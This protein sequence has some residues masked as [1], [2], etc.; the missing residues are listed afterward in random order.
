[1]PL[2]SIRKYEDSVR[3]RVER[4]GPPAGVGSRLAGRVL[5]L[6]RF[7]WGR[8]LIIICGFVPPF[9]HLMYT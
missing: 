4:L 8:R 3:F 1:M 9:T 2:R 6:V 5:E 7:S